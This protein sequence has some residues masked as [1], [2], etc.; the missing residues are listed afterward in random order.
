MKA[1]TECLYLRSKGLPALNQPDQYSRYR[2]DQ[3][4]VQKPSKCVGCY[5]AQ[6]PQHEE[7]GEYQPKHSLG[8]Y[9]FDFPFAG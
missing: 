1:A 3:K 5:H 2:Q 6:Q 7:N 9:V 4:N 8:A